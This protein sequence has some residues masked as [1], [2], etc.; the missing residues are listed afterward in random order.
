MRGGGRGGGG[1]V[2]RRRVEMELFQ[3]RSRVRSSGQ[4]RLEEAEM[5]GDENIN[6]TMEL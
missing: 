6:R 2:E 5:F 4:N 1:C 3:F